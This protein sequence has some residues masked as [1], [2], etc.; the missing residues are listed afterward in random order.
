MC[1]RA[2][3]VT[4]C[5]SLLVVYFLGVPVI[6]ASRVILHYSHPEQFDGTVPSISETAA[7]H[8][9]SFLFSLGMSI[10]AC[11]AALSVHMIAGMHRRR[12][13][14]L[15]R[16]GAETNSI[17][18]VLGVAYALGMLAALSLFMLANVSLS[19]QNALHVAFSVT[20]FFAQ[21]AFMVL[22]WV[23]WRMLLAR[24]RPMGITLHG[25]L[26]V[27]RGRLLAGIVCVSLI[28]LFLFLTKD[29]GIFTDRLLVQHVYTL[30]ELC[31]AF[32]LLAYAP[33]HYPDARRHYGYEPTLGCT[34]TAPE[35]A[36]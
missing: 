29:R 3:N 4:R 7:Y 13:D 6:V 22:D 16:C 28:F 33:L 35:S 17:G 21:V 20:F 14:D 32:M 15:G 19:D 9:G 27:A 25:E 1:P 30:A 23:C 18:I 10:V 31:T 36:G 2:C 8:P 26:R 24:T 5:M 11:S 34:T 12:L